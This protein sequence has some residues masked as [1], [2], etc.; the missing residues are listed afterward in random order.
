MVGGDLLDELILAQGPGIVVDMEAQGPESSD[1]LLA[2]VLE[3]EETDAAVLDWVE[4][5]AW[6]RATCNTV[7]GGVS[8]GREEVGSHG[9]KV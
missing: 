5:T 6:F 3:D 8:G 9:G 4:E 2:D 1:S 7:V